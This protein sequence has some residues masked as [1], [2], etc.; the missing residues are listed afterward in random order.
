MFSNMPGTVHTVDQKDYDAH[1]KETLKKL[2]WQ[3]GTQDAGYRDDEVNH[4][5]QS[6]TDHKA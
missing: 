5:P 4:S 1:R 6:S 2:G 3:D